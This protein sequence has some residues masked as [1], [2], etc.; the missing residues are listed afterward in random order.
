MSLTTGKY[1]LKLL[2]NLDKSYLYN[3]S[4]NHAIRF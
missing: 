4:A 2:N 3:L 1:N